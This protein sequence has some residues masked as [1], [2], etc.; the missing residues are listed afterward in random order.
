MEYAN[1]YFEEVQ[2]IAK[3]IDL[4]TIEKMVQII[5]DQVTV[6]RPTLSQDEFR[7]AIKGIFDTVDVEHDGVV[8]FA[9]F[10]T[11]VDIWQR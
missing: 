6:L 7:E 4:N 5:E 3:S 8:D 9:A 11:G 1:R 10:Y 2:T